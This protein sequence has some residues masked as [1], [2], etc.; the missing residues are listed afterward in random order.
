[1]CPKARALGLPRAS[2]ARGEVAE[3]RFVAKALSLGF[4]VLRP[5]GD[6]QP[7]DFVLQS[8][9]R[10]TRVQVKSAWTPF[11]KGV[12]QIM[13]S[14]GRRTRRGLRSYTLDDVDFIV[15]YLGPQDDW[16]IIPVT[17]LLTTIHF[18]LSPRSLLYRYRERWD[19][20]T[21]SG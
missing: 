20:L 1:M 7:Y 6:N 21:A 4:A 13:T 5:F 10:M 11:R 12:Y 9:G 8:H 19:L 17:E 15:V 3:A 14:M 18:F 2:K 16:F